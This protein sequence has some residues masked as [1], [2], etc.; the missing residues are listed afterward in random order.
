MKVKA[1]PNLDNVVASSDLEKAVWRRVAV[2]K[3]TGNPKPTVHS[4][5]L[6]ERPQLVGWKL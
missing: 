5:N 4:S 1:L 6:V 3:P 2:F